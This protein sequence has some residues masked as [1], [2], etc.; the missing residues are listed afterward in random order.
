MRTAI[1]SAAVILLIAPR[2]ASQTLDIGGIPL[3]IDQDASEAV[4]SMAAYQVKYENS[5]RAW[6]VSQKVGDR[7]EYLGSFD[8]VDGK[9]ASIVKSYRAVDA[10]DVARIYTQASKEVRRLGGPT[11]VMREV[12]YTDGVIRVI[13]TTCGRY[14]LAYSLPWVDGT[15]GRIGTGISISVGTP[16]RRN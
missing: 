10:D 1:F 8:A 2:L 4:Q 15:N 14:R 3:R 6:F 13:E 11:C 9:V 5:I 16:V 12:E 7:F